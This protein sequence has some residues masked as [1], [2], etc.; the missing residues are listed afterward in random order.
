MAEVETRFTVCYREDLWVDKKKASRE[1]ERGGGMKRFTTVRDNKE[2]IFRVAK[3]I[4]TENQDVI[5][6]K[7]IRGDDGSLSLDDAQRN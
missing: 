1:N 2:N 4:R 3:Q 7:C 6:E 5:G